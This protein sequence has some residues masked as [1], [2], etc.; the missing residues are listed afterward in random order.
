M[1]TNEMMLSTS[2]AEIYCR[3]NIEDQAYGEISTLAGDIS[4]KFK[5]RRV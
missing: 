2:R 5:S 4:G 3:Y 1:N